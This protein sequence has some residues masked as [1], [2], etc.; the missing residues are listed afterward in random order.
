MK[1]VN[2]IDIKFHVPSTH[3]HTPHN[4]QCQNRCCFPNALDGVRGTEK[5]YSRCK[6]F[7]S[8]LQFAIA[9]EKLV[10]LQ[11]SCNVKVG[12]D[13]RYRIEICEQAKISDHLIVGIRSIP[14]CQVVF[15]GDINTPWQQLI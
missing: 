8:P 12:I 13:L 4:K 11:C 3:T 9:A 1:S 7:R 5:R 2:L 14:N 10:V 15:E 6:V